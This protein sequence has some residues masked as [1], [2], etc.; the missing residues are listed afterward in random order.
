MYIY[1]REIRGILIMGSTALDR[2]WPPQVRGMALLI[3]ILNA[4]WKWVFSFMHPPFLLWVKRGWY[5]LNRNLEWPQGCSG[6]LWR[7]ERFLSSSGFH[8]PNRSARSVVIITT[9][10]TT[11]T[12]T[13]IEFSLGGS[14]PYSSTDKTDTNK[15]T[16][17]QYKQNTVY[18]GTDIT[19][20]PTHTHTHTIQNPHVHTPTHYKTHTYTHPHIT[21]PT[22]THNRTL[23]NQLKQPQH[24]IHTKLNSQNTIQYPQCKVILM[25]ILILWPRTSP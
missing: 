25:Y 3:L 4:R 20:T 17:T 24:K 1:S 18:A 7:K 14:S 21:K 13:A 19:K 6:A 22:H 10:T 15:Y 8:T 5:V 12:T 11:T 2:P 9:T 16:K 23:Q